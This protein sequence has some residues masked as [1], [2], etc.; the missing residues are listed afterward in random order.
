MKRSLAAVLV[1]VSLALSAVPA[2]AHRPYF[3]ETDITADK[4]WSVSDPTISTAI[5]ATLDTRATRTTTPSTAARASA[6]C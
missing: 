3:E 1:L 2:S 5:Y 6:S 4:P